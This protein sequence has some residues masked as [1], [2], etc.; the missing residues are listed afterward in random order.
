MSWLYLVIAGVFEIVW[1]YAMKQAHGFTRLTPFSH[2][3][4]GHAGCRLLPCVTFRWALP[5]LPGPE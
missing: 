4:Y 3:F 5:I 1:A 2:H